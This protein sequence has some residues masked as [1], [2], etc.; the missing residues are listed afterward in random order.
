MPHRFLAMGQAVI[1][2]FAD[3]REQVVLHWKR[4]VFAQNVSAERQWQARLALPP[5]AE[6]DDLCESRALV[7]EL[8]LVNDQAGIGFAIAHGVENFV[9][10]ED[11]GFE[12][13]EIELKR[14][15][16]ARHFSWY[17]NRLF[18]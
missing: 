10:G 11:D 4:D 18:L 7:S 8:A 6:V 1:D 16:C 12:F 17:G 14:E 9:E 15:K 3:D 13:T 2:A 5:F